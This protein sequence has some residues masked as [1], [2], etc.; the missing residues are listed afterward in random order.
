M[1]GT[2]EYSAVGRKFLAKLLKCKKTNDFEMFEWEERQALV[3]Q[4]AISCVGRCVFWQ[5]NRKGGDG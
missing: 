3:G 5:D 1:L 4:H 2:K